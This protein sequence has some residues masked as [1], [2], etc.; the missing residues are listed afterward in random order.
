MTEPEIAARLHAYFSEVF[1]HP[2][3][4]LDL[5]TDLLNDWFVDSFGVIQTVQFLEDSFAVALTRGDINAAHFHS[6]RAL[7]GLVRRK[8]T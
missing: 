6:I 3:R 1:P 2:G 8:L 5:D 4:A 7:A